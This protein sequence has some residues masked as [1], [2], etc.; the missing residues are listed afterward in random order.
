[1]A[2]VAGSFY[3][4]HSATLEQDLDSMLAEA[5]TDACCP[6]AIIAPHA[7]YIYSGPVAASL[8]ARVR[9][10]A[11]RINR[12]ILL[13]PSHRVG[14]RGIA[15][16]TADYFQTPL[17]DIPLAVDT[18]K[19]ITEL[20]NTGFLDQAHEQ[21]HSLEV[22]LPFLQTVL[23]DFQLVP[24]VVGDAEAPD[25]ARVLDA[26]WG[27][28]ET[29]VVI[30]SD[31]SHFKTY[32]DALTADKETCRKIEALD[33]D[34]DGN[35]ACGCRP[36]NGLLH[37]ARNK[38]LKI[39]AI[40][41]R[42]SGDTAG[43][44]DRVVGYG[45]FVVLESD[46]QN[47]KIEDSATAESDANPTV[48]RYSTSQRQILLQIA[49]NAIEHQLFKGNPLSVELESLPDTLTEQLASFVTL[50]LQG[51]LR[52]CIG[53][54][55]AHR[56]LAT[57]VAANAYAAAFQDPRFAPVT[58]AEYSD[59]EIHISVLSKPELMEVTSREALITRIRPGIDGIILEE[60][61]HRATYLPSVWEQ[62]TEPQQFI[63]EL[64]AKAGLSRQG[65]A[66]ATRIYRYTTEEFS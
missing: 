25:V 34:I 50:N 2:A 11:H 37:L 47:E 22:H 62:L 55:L 51:R 29:L 54:L 18:I 27:G 5:S 59:L 26:L 31:L 1:M 56:P 45:S 4:G 60:N 15:A 42:N 44:K 6:K 48:Q 17:G 32:Q 46:S 58:Q 38:G 39:S 43:S 8:Y 14:F 57:D 28:E 10:A 9:N 66:E 35:Q 13:G 36:I 24:L 63:S 19:S 20:P 16:S 65:W 23:D 40:D 61:G 53:S 12:V 21:E 33:T 52:G 30:S 7:G 49:R 3:P 64:R 41:V